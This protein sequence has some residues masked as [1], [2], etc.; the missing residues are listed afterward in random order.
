[1]FRKNSEEERK[2]RTRKFDPSPADG[3]CILNTNWKSVAGDRALRDED[4]DDDAEGNGR[5]NVALNHRMPSVIGIVS[6]S[7]HK[8][9]AGNLVIDRAASDREGR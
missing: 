4:D 2:E 7:P 6:L 8:E 9:N 1:M 3:A 5:G